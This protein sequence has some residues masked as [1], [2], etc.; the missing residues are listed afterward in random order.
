MSRF[1]NR[2]MLCLLVVGLVA[3]VVAKERTQEPVAERMQENAQDSMEV[4]RVKR[5]YRS[6][7]VAADWPEGVLCGEPFTVDVTMANVSGSRWTNT[8]LHK[9]GPLNGED[10]IFRPD[11]RKFQL[12]EGG[13]VPFHGEHKFT[14]EL[15]APEE[16]GTYETSWSMMAKG[17]SFGE[18]VSKTIRVYC[19]D[20]TLGRA[21]FPE[22]VACGEEFTAE[23]RMRNTGKTTWTE[24]SFYKLGPVLKADE[25]FRPDGEKI[26]MP[27]FTDVPVGDKYMFELELTAPDAP[28][29]YET[30][31]TMMDGG[32]PFG[33]EVSRTINVVCKRKKDRDNNGRD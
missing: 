3:P 1:M 24:E 2:A 27:D 30:K 14:L 16:K 5:Y 25:V 12:P 4:A 29:S 23:V 15:T 6:A 28:G 9:F 21:L 20:A 19:N 7:V 22:E 13:E 18:P 8:G 26:K 17:I 33:E 31:W 10:E 32:K 11:G